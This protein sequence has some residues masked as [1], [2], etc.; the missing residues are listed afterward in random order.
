MGSSFSLSA[1]V[2]SSSS[3]SSSVPPPQVPHTT[4]QKN[5]YT[6]NTPVPAQKS[7]V[8]SSPSSSSS[9][10]LS[11]SPLSSSPVC[12]KPWQPH[13]NDHRSLIC[14]FCG[15]SSCSRENYLTQRTD[16]PAIT[17]LHST[18]ISSGIIASQRPSSRLIQQHDIITQCKQKGVYCIINLQLNGEHALCGDGLQ[19]ESGFSYRPEQ[20]SD[21]GIYYYN[22]GKN[23]EKIRK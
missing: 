5:H 6:Y 11:V 10:S 20:F 13:V 23:R 17:G 2:T 14:R 12:L 22:F 4:P 19:K 1:S 9:S 21:H 8:L 18:W 15:G 7:L 3:A 16:T